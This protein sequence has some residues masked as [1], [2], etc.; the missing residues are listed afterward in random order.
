MLIIFSLWF[1]SC[2]FN[3]SGLSFCFRLLTNQA[4]ICNTSAQRLGQDQV[5]PKNAS[6]L[7]KDQFKLLFL[8]TGALNQGLS[9]TQLTPE[10]LTTALSAVLTNK[11]C[12]YSEK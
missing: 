6:N 12:F 10:R 7:N 8:E 5:W 11:V 1:W 4:G 3:Q 9:R 2:D